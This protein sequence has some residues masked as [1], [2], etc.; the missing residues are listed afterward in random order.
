MGSGWQG[1]VEEQ[2]PRLGY[3]EER[4][5][6]PMIGVAARNSLADSL[7]G[8]IA[9]GGAFSPSQEEGGPAAISSGAPSEVH[10]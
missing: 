8:D 5:G 2:P 7:S 4:I 10:Q 1:A 9:S 6:T 3:G